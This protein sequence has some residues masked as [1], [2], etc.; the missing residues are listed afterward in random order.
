[1][2]TAMRMRSLILIALVLFPGFA[3]GETI[4][5]PLGSYNDPLLFGMTRDQVERV[6]SAPLIY[7]S[8][9]RGSER[10][11]VERLASVPGWYPVDTRVILQFRRGRL[12]GWRR[13]WQM[14]PYSF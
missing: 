3:R 12:T 5:R 13:D 10:Y 8:G 1:M 4:Q 9:A 2:L 7:L 6:F 14:R 11:M